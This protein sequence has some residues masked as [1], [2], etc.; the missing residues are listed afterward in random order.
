MTV[1][2]E[3]LTLGL[4]DAKQ[5]IELRLALARALRG[6]G[7]VPAARACCEEVLATC[8]RT[9]DPTR[10]YAPDDRPAVAAGRC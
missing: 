10:P 7:D 4:L 5:A 6:A 2:W 1:V 8:R 3:E 9:A